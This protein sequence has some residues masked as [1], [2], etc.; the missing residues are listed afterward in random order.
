MCVQPE[1]TLTGT[2]ANT[3]ESGEQPQQLRLPHIW[4]QNESETNRAGYLQVWFRSREEFPFA[5]RR[6]L[7]LACDTDDYSVLITVWTLT[8]WPVTL[9]QSTDLIKLIEAVSE[10]PKPFSSPPIIVMDVYGGSYAG[11]FCSLYV[12][13]HQ[14]LMEGTADVYSLFKMYHLQRPDIFN[15]KADLEFIYEVIG[16]HAK[17]ASPS[18]SLSLPPNGPASACSASAH[19]GNHGNGSL[20]TQRSRDSQSLHAAAT[21]QLSPETRLSDCPT[22]QPAA[23]C[24]P[25]DTPVANGV[26]PRP[27]TVRGRIA[28][29]RSAHESLCLPGPPTGVRPGGPYSTHTG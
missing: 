19:H 17:H 9:G 23:P 14:L 29:S 25:A 12:L 26:P 8:R 7:H 22:Q 4:P 3:E 2:E 27:R 28:L 5:V 20:T 18:N 15:S 1:D 6:E 24:C 13:Y 11:I 10:Q 16:Y 21:T